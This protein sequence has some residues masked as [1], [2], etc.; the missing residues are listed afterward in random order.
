M[1]SHTNSRTGNRA[2]FL[3]GLKDGVPIGLGY[4]SV[5]FAF[6]IAAVSKGVPPWIA[7]FISMTNLTSAGQM[8][9]L[10]LMVA[11]C[12]MWEMILTQCIINL[13]YALMSISLAQKTDKTVRLCD[14]FLIAFG[15]TDEV[16][17]VASGQRGLVGRYY[18][19]GLITA[20]YLGWSLGT[21]G[22]SV[23]SGLLPESVMTALGIAIYGMFV[24]IVI[25]PAKTSK[26]VALVLLGSVGLACLFR[27]TPVLDRVSSGFVIILCA[28]TAAALGAT[29]API[30]EEPEAGSEA[31]VP[32]ADASH[33]EVSAAD[34]T[35][36]GGGQA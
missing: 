32:A 26:P 14:R 9:G 34:V 36:E 18:L 29:F 2:S 7:L 5:S 12:T 21:L 28:V 8:A 25:P 13:R 11:G 4:L 22:G 19:F 24:A 27:W 35:G 15:N 23:A 30:K 6:G 20:P 16:F 1:D 33:A 3:K 17:A 31:E 10:D